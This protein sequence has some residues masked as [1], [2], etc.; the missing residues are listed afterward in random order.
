MI[1]VPALAVVHQHKQQHYSTHPFT[2]SLNRKRLENKCFGHSSWSLCHGLTCCC[3]HREIV[4]RCPSNRQGRWWNQPRFTQ[5]SATR[6]GCHLPPPVRSRRTTA[7]GPETSATCFLS[8][9]RRYWRTRGEF[10]LFRKPL[11][12]PTPLASVAR[13]A[14]AMVIDPEVVK[15]WRLRTS[16]QIAVCVCFLY[17]FVPCPFKIVDLWAMY[18][19]LLSLSFYTTSYMLGIAM[20]KNVST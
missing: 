5:Q 18:Y 8:E 16:S 10:S 11:P 2:M 17:P 15:S 14:L 3:G 7:T 1:K 9:P 12:P 13:N 19:L 4:D 20:F 6:E